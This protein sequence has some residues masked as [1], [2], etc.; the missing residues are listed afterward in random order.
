MARLNAVHNRLFTTRNIK[1]PGSLEKDPQ[2]QLEERMEICFAISETNLPVSYAKLEHL[3]SVMNRIKTDN[4][5]CLGE[6][7][8]NS[9]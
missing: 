5:A 3:F 9:L 1:L 4:R 7:R 2:L 6:Y 8:L